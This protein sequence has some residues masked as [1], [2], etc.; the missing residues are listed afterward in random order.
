MLPP[1]LLL[2][3][4]VAVAALVRVSWALASLA[5][6]TYRFMLA[7]AVGGQRPVAAREAVEHLLS[8]L[9]HNNGLLSFV[10]AAAAAASA[11]LDRSSAC[12]QCG[13]QRERLQS[14]RPASANAPHER[15]RKELGSSSG[16]G[17]GGERMN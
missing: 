8:D 5:R 13:R 2:A 11:Q 3:L 6:S 9:A 17:S 15:G 12:K 10:A 4:V 1:L 14:Q 16:G 7:L